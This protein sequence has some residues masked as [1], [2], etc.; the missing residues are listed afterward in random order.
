MADII[1]DQFKIKEVI[2]S[3]LEE[4]L[5]SSTVEN[6]C[7][8]NKEMKGKL[9]KNLNFQFFTIYMRLRGGVSFLKWICPWPLE[10]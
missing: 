7:T 4:I 1:K 6:T 2:V 10:K 8:K 5:S 3:N 9:K